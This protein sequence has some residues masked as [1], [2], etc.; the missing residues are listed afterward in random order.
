MSSLESGEY[1][2]GCHGVE[3]S[4]SGMR[5]QFG[6]GHGK[7][8]LGDA[9]FT[10]AAN[11]AKQSANQVTSGMRIFRFFAIQK[12]SSYEEASFNLNPID[13]DSNSSKSANLRRR[14]PDP[15]TQHDGPRL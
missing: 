10:F 6:E 1:T 11:R 14:R 3:T 8:Q 5:F 9:L 15:D 4:E 2:L 12:S 7:Q 13:H